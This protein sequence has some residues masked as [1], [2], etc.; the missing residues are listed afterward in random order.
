VLTVWKSLGAHRTKKPAHTA[1]G[2]SSETDPADGASQTL[3][4]KMQ[5]T[6]NEANIRAMTRGTRAAHLAA[7]V[8]SHNNTAGETNGTLTFVCW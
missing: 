4:T 5:G 2:S 1:G 7:T 3:Y 8:R 6:T